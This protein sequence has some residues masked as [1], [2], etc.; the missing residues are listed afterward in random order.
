[1]RYRV[2]PVEAQVNRKVPSPCQAPPRIRSEELLLVGLVLAKYSARLLCPSLS[3]SPLGSRTYARYAAS[4]ASAIP[5]ALVSL[6][7]TTVR[8]K[9]AAL[10]FANPSFTK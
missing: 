3:E 8:L 5:L 1:M 2:P 4:Q 9:A 7:A 6:G 10:L